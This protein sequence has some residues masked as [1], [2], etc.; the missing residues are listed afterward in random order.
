MRVLAGSVAM[1]L[2]AFLADQEAMLGR[3]AARPLMKALDPKRCDP[4]LLEF[5]AL[6][7]EF[8]SMGLRDTAGRLVCTSNAKPIRIERP[9]QEQWFEDGLRTPG[10][11]AGDALAH[12]LGRWISVLTYPVRRDDG[13]LAGL[14]GLPVDLLK[15]QDRLFRA[16]PKEASVLVVDRSRRVLMRSTRPEAWIGKPLPAEFSKATLAPRDGVV[17]ARGLDGNPRLWAVATVSRSGWQVM[18]GLPENEVLAPYRAERDELLGLGAAMLAAVL[19]LAWW[20]GTVI[21]RP[22]V[23][24]GRTAARVAAGEIGRPRAARRPGGARGGRPAVQPHARCPCRARRGARGA[25]R[26]LRPACAAGSRDHPARRPRGPDRGGQRG[27]RGR[28]R[29]ERRGAARHAGAGA[30]ARGRESPISGSAGR[31]PRGRKACSSRRAAAIATARCFPS[32]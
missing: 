32:R 2:D 30:A 22:V 10:L 6:H 9:G 20:A 23:A 18:V 1:Q 26:P 13:K 14:V 24:L 15:L 17:S 21:A 28:L 11:S 16:T 25:R 19:A 12:P 7:P 31:S 27:R 4:A 8:M 29:L 3:V 5:A